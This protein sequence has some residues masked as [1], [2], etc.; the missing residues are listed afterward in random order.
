MN[1]FA[2]SLGIL[3][4]VQLLY[5][6]DAKALGKWKKQTNA[7]TSKLIMIICQVHVGFGAN[8]LTILS[9]VLI[10]T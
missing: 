7:N 1:C 9:L 10:V 6:N 2:A 8:K 3:L 5:L 4:L